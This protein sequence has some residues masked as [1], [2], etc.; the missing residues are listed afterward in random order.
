MKKQEED[1]PAEDQGE[2]G[3]AAKGEDAEA[4][5][6]EEPA[7]KKKATAEAGKKVE[8]AF[9]YEQNAIFFLYQ[10]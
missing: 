4:D 2:D 5:K 6:V 7:A 9:R 10:M 8:V 3:E 1:E